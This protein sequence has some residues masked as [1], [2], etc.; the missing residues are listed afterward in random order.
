MALKTEVILKALTG[1]QDGS[2]GKDVRDK[3][4]DG[5]GSDLRPFRKKCE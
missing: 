2:V 1:D 4:G 5:Q 3:L